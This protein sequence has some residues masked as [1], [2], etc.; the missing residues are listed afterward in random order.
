MTP[1]RILRYLR[2]TPMRAE[3]KSAGPAQVGTP[4]RAVRLC[5]ETHKTVINMR[6]DKPDRAS[7]RVGNLILPSR[8]GSA[9]LV[10]VVK[11]HG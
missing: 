11:A 7:T 2:I 1:V 10:M 5:L 3:R 4:D 9:H 6:Y 8:A